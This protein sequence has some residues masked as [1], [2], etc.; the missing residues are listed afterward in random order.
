MI[1]WCII[2]AAAL[3]EKRRGAGGLGTNVAGLHVFDGES[4]G[5]L[6]FIPTSFLKMFGL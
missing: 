5:W 3:G 1:E 6:C 4:G 2:I